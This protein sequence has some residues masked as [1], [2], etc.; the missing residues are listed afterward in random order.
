MTFVDRVK[1]I[2][3][4]PRTEWPRIAAEPATVQSIYTGWVMILAA[5]GP[6]MV[7]LS[8]LMISI[9]G[10][11]FGLRAAI[12]MYVMTLISVAVVALVA[13]LLAPTFGGT[14]DYVRSLKLVAYSFTAVWV[15]ELALIVPVLGGIV[16]LVGAIYGFYLF[17]LGAPL[18]GR[19]S[20]D[21]AV[22]YTLVVV[23]GTIVL[24][25]VI[26]AIMF[27]LIYAPLAGGVIG[28]VR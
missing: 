22:P 17:F 8:A 18:L 14:K 25:F 28:P 19:C 13:D 24:M 23:L 27:S 15:A 6:V 1:A 16:T 3:L 26:R 4:N 9:L 5:I 20:S 21:R 12:G 11:A 10:P 2:L 7:L